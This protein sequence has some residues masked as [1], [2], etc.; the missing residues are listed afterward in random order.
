MIPN[1]AAL[2]ILPFDHRHSFEHGLFG[3][4]LPLKA[5]QIEQVRE[6]KQIVYQG[7]LQSEVPRGEGG[8]LVDEQFGARILQDARQRGFI[9][10]C[11]VEKSGQDEFDFEYGDDFAAHIE[12][13]NPGYVKVLVRYNPSGD[14]ALNA[15]QR[16][17]LAA[18][19]QYLQ[20]QER[21]LMFELLVPPT[22]EQTAQTFDTQTRPA[23]MVQ[24][25]RELQD[26]GIEP[27]LWKVEGVGQREDAQALVRAAQRSGRSNVNLIVLGRGADDTQVKAWLEVAAMTPGFCGFAVG[28]TTFW[29]ALK[30]LLAGELSRPQAVSEIASNYRN[31]VRDFEAA[32]GA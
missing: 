14:A 9:T 7:F 21:R 23:L 26:A 30:R 24:A 16:G 29:D 17:K 25:I 11:P 13:M 18:L 31:W 8:I 32:R 10:A 2:Y 4:T 27:Q 15:R 19:S 12:A 3:F 20:R 5:G 1:P 6:A 22:P 28:R